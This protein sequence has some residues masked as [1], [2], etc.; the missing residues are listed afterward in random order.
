MIHV[1]T[2]KRSETMK[3]RHSINDVFS[4]IVNAEFQNDSNNSFNFPSY[5]ISQ[6]LKP[7]CFKA[8]YLM[9]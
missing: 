6:Y 9:L 1:D 3:R 8:I 5:W 4:R 2:E 7:P